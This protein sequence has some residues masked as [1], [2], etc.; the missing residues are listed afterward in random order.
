MARTRHQRSSKETPD[1]PMD[2]TPKQ[3]KRRL[4]I[5][6]RNKKSKAYKRK[7]DYHERKLSALEGTSVY[8][9]QKAAVKEARDIRVRIESESAPLHHSQ[10][11]GMVYDPLVHPYMVIEKMAEGCLADE[12]ALEIGVLPST[13]KAWASKYEAFGLAVMDGM[14]LC[15]AWWVK[16][17]R[18]RLDDKDFNTALYKSVMQNNFGWGAGMNAGNNVTI[19]NHLNVSADKIDAQTKHLMGMPVSELRELQSLLTTGDEDE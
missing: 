2:E 17:S 10:T 18:E 1:I 4:A 13:L 11:N 7:Q 16:Q 3:K 5:E 19:N 15:R 8:E 9:W 6:K 14:D 12:L